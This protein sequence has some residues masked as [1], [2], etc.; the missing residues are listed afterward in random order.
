MNFPTAKM[1]VLSTH[2]GRSPARGWL[3]LDFRAV[4]LD[5]VSRIYVDLDELERIR[6]RGGEEGDVLEQARKLLGG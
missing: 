2:E 5:G 4:D 3:E 6:A 1:R